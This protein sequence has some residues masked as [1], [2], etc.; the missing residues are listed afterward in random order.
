MMVDP[1]IAHDE[2]L[3]LEKAALIAAE[4]EANAYWRAGLYGLARDAR[5]EAAAARERIHQLE[6]AG[7][8]E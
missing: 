8:G 6:D 2:E 1:K 7:G 4:Q 3:L 5:E